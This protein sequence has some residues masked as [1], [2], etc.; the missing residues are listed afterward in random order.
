MSIRILSRNEIDAAKWNN[1]IA[2]SAIGLPYGFTFYMDAV[3]TNWEGIVVD[4]YAAVMP[5]PITKFLFRK[6]VYQPL[7]CQQLGVFCNKKNNALMEKVGRFFL[8][9]YKPKQYNF[10]YA[11]PSFSTDTIL[12]TNIVLPLSTDYESLYL[13]YN[14]NTKRN[15]TK[16]ANNGIIIQSLAP[17]VAA[18]FFIKNTAVLDKNFKTKHSLVVSHLTK[19]ENYHFVGAFAGN[20][21]I[22][23]VGYYKMPERLITV[24]NATNKNGKNLGAAHLLFDSIIQQYANTKFTL[25]FEG[26]SVASIAQFYRGFGGVE[27]N[28]FAIIKKDLSIFKPIFQ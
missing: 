7:F 21:L 17:K 16:A 12:R 2:E 23:F 20:E 10:N 3:C 8:N 26:S 27:E 24:F 15:I 13:Q 14:N 11:N 18:D 22:G 28:Y 4:N 25:D 5:I 6:K 19:M 1:T 9:H